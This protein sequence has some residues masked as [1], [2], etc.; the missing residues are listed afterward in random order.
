M[1]INSIPEGESCY[2]QLLHNF[3]RLRVESILCFESFSSSA[4]VTCFPSQRRWKRD[5]KALL[6][7]I[8]MLIYCLIVEW[9]IT[10][11]ITEN[12][13]DV[14]KCCCCYLNQSTTS[15]NNF[16]FTD[17]TYLAAHIKFITPERPKKDSTK[18][19][20]W[21]CSCGGLWNQFVVCGS[22]K[23]YFSLRYPS[24]FIWHMLTTCWTLHK[25]MTI[26]HKMFPRRQ[27]EI[28]H[29]KQI[30]HR[31]RS[32]IF[33]IITNVL[34]ITSCAIIISSIKDCLFFDWLVVISIV[35]AVCGTQWMTERE[36]KK[37]LNG[38]N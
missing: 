32:E 33:S 37:Y 4:F 22:W 11:Y 31:P 27:T 20:T 30:A 3:E 18:M 10:G 7:S 24:F 2:F 8:I 34:R 17:G 6:K 15:S 13:C 1:C 16:I 23:T 29:Q 26:D 12:K 36:E 25:I 28:K 19:A 14:V 5:S 21:V 38:N 35:D 9:S